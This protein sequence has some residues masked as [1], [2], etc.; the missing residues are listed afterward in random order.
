MVDASIV[1]LPF[2]HWVYLSDQ[3]MPTGGLVMTSPEVFEVGQTVEFQNEGLGVIT[4]VSDDSIY[5][6]SDFFTGW[7]RKAEY[8]DLLGTE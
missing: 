6:V 5:I 7:M 3:G 4:G 1:G 8:F 2:G